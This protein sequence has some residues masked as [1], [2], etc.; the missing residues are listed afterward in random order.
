MYNSIFTDMSS[1]S[2]NKFLTEDVKK[3]I[4]GNF[5]PIHELQLN[6]KKEKNS[7]TNLVFEISLDFFNY[8]DSE[9]KELEPLGNLSTNLFNYPFRKNANSTFEARYG[10]QVKDFKSH[11]EKI[12]D[13]ILE[14]FCDRYHGIIRGLRYYTFNQTM[15]EFY[16][17]GTPKSEQQKNIEVKIN[18]FFT[19]VENVECLIHPLLTKLRMNKNI[20]FKKRVDFLRENIEK[21]KQ[22]D[23][24]YGYV[25]KGKKMPIG[26]KV[27]IGANLSRNTRLK[28]AEIYVIPYG[29]QSSVQIPLEY[30][31]FLK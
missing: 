11:Q 5:N 10:F 18:S 14:H 9:Y 25:V 7:L 23:F 30:L 2:K 19:K 17:A 16:T 3:E 13:F 12:S 27:K 24:I 22:G 6:F 26:T 28:N 15:P 1:I 8:L 29:S 21:Y 31:V 4:L 20:S